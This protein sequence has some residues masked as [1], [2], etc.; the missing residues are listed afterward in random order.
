MPFA[1]TL[2]GF[3][4]LALGGVCAALALLA[5]G[6]RFS[7]RLDVLTH[8]APLYLVGSAVA[9]VLILLG[10]GTLRR[11]VGLALALVGALA[12]SALMAPEFLR[13]TGPTAPRGSPGEIKVIEFN[14][15]WDN[16]HPERVAE[17]LKAEN[18]DI[19]LMAEVR[20]AVRKLIVDRTG[21]E[22]V[23]IR[24]TAHIYSR[25]PYLG[26]HR[27][28]LTE[29][30]LTFVNGTY[31]AG[32]RPMEVV[33]AR[34]V[35]PT[36]RKSPPQGPFLRQVVSM[37]PRERMVLGGDFNST[38]WS[39]Q[40]QRDDRLLGLTRRDRAVG[41]W[42]TGHSGLWRWPAPFPLLPIDHIYAGPGWA[43]TSVRRGPR[44]GSDHY[45]LIVTLTP[46]AP[47]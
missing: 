43:T 16:P 19:V 7:P 1:R 4:G 6:G 38:P 35:W 21:L 45:P 9:G 23:G 33:V 8:F 22:V 25:I 39:F 27:P 14:V 40:R 15:W 46:V 29:K 42:P 32:G 12:A 10:A 5:Q 13:D 44:L 30:I 17:W 28:P 37:L 36:S 18:P 2:F 31:S 3:L 34:A 47:R 26:M 41:T 11:Q 20:P 24:T